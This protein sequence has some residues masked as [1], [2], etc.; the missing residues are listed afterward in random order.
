M[1]HLR[2]ALRALADVAR[3]QATIRFVTAYARRADLGTEA[4]LEQFGPTLTVDQVGKAVVELAD[5][6]GHRP[7]AYALTA[8]GL[9]PLS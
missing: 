9:A 3:A 1:D 5:S 7:G 2:E 6:T 8:A 4:F